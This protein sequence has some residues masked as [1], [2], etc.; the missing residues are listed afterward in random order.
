MTFKSRLSR[1][2]DQDTS[3]WVGRCDLR[4]VE[5][6][7]FSSPEQLLSTDKMGEQQVLEE[8]QAELNKRMKALADPAALAMKATR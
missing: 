2:D 7:T 4:S 6:R 1:E 3:K 8:A 5:N